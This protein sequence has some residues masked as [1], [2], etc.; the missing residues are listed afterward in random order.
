MN[1][2]SRLY[3]MYE[4]IFVNNAEKAGLIITDKEFSFQ[5]IKLHIEKWADMFSQLG[6]QEGDRVVISTDDRLYF[7]VTWLALWKINAIP[8]P[9]EPSS[10]AAEIG[11]A[12]ESGKPQ[13]ICSENPIHLDGMPEGFERCSFSLEPEWVVGK[14]SENNKIASM[15]NSAFYCYTSGTTG[16]PKCVMYDIDATIAIIDSLIDAFKLTNKD[17]FMTPLPPSLP[18]VIFTAFLPALASGAT[19][20]VLDEPIPSRTL[21]VMKNTNTTV[22]FAVPYFYKLMIEAMKIRNVSH[23]DALRLCVATSAYL[24]EKTFSDFYDLTGIPIRSIFCSSEAFYCTFNPKDNMEKLKKSV[25]YPLKGV[26]LKIGDKA[27]QEVEPLREGEILISGTHKSSGYFCRAEL[28]KKVYIDGWVHTGDLGYMDKDGYLYITGRIS[29]TI[30]VGGYLVNP[31]EV[32]SI[33]N[34]YPGISESVIVG[35]KDEEIGEIVVAKVVLKDGAQLD[36]N[37][38]IRYCKE[39]LLPFK[40]PNR[41][42]VIDAVP[43]SRY[44]KIRRLS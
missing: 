41:I 29:D 36:E 8:I 4:D 18:S 3:K 12:I 37:D 38:V 39:M 16:T 23:F 24:D 32:E 21:K 10:G 1:I 6:M 43:K 22:F 26:Q 14:I 40:I 13:W 5:E 44:G 28:E 42:E 17:V 19:L 35:E 7:I 25:G 31:L 34:S 2:K 9:I 33:L 11:R 30:N 15:E 27:G 20:V